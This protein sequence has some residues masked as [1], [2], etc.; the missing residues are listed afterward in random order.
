MARGNPL[1]T[2]DAAGGWADPVQ[3]DRLGSPK[4]RIKRDDMWAIPG[5]PDP[6]RTQN[7]DRP[8]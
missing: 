2:R 8:H 1:P 3:A 4:S 6:S 7:G 5:Y